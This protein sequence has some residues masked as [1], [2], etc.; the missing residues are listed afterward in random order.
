MKREDTVDYSQLRNLKI[1]QTSP[2]IEIPPPLRS[3]VSTFSQTAANANSTS[4]MGPRSEAT[5]VAVATK[6]ISK[7]CTHQ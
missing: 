2:F 5:F 7:N 6:K 4:L 3:G 1:L